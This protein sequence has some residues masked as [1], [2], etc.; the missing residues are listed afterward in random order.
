MERK[1]L[2]ATGAIVFS[3][4]AES[5]REAMTLVKERLRAAHSVR[6]NRHDA[7]RLSR[8]LVEAFA[9]GR[10]NFI[11]MD[12]E[13]TRLVCGEYGGVYEQPVTRRLADSLRHLIPDAL[14]MERRTSQ[15][16][17]GWPTLSG[18]SSRL[19]W[20]W[21]Y[22]AGSYTMAGRQSQASDRSCLEQRAVQPGSSQ[23]ILEDRL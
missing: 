9:A 5:A 22:A 23:P 6:P 15:S 12:G 2:V 4:H 11:V 7:N 19:L 16:R 17:A 20:Q 3:Q 14:E 13:R 18:I 21:S 1:Y 8:A 10:L